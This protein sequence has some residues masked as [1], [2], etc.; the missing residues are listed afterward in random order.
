MTVLP[1]FL[2]KRA[3]LTPDRIAFEMEERKVTFSELYRNSLILSG[4]LVALGVR[5]GD[6]ISVFMANSIEL[7]ELLFALK[8]LGAITVLHNL[9]LTSKEL[10][11]QVED[12]SSR[13]I[14]MDKE[15]EST[16]QQSK[17]FKG[18]EKIVTFSHVHSL[19]DSNF[20]IAEEFSLEEIDTIMY[21][22]G[23]TGFPKGV[24]QT[25]G[26]H[27][28]S[29]TGSALNMGLHEND[30][31]L[32]AVPIFHISGL[33]I[34]MRSVIYGMRVII[35]RRF[36]ADAVHQDLMERQVSIVSVV[37]TMLSN[38]LERLGSD[39]Y[40]PAFRCMLVGGGPVPKSIL[41]ECIRK[42]IPVYQTYGMTE[43]CSQ[44]VTLSPDFAM[45]KIGSAGKPL[46]PCQLKVI[47]DG[48]DVGPMETGEIVVKGPNVTTGYYNRDDS[49]FKA[50]KAGWLYT[51]DLGYVDEDGF[52]FV[53]DRRSD[54][55]ISGGENVYPAEIEAVLVSHPS[56][57]EAGVTGISDDQWGQVPVAFVVTDMEEELME[58][59][60]MPF[61]REQL[62]GYKIPKQIYVVEKLPRNASNKLMRRELLK[63]LPD[64][65]DSDEN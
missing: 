45:S 4:K 29:A 65:E 52:L 15:Q 63:M 43:T 3:A 61:V 14:L 9:R 36:E 26:N 10:S 19:I 2:M 37:T 17:E 5:R 51:G 20:S 44:I 47:K 31:W 28:W 22:S 24:K 12:A 40:P 33:S 56:I 48:M 23:T 38:L 16:L 46:F 42:S 58:E 39:S 6:R 55:I 54:L 49:T 57:K 64:W 59:N 62:A 60:V 35:H 8:N 25:Y 7:V 34:L 32:L 18:T 13:F 53:V 11:Y 30:C 50:I 21:T 41:E 1:N 27:F